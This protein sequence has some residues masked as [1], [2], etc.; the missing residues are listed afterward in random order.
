MKTSDEIATDIFR[1]VKRS[2]LAT[3][4]TGKIINGKERTPNSTKEDVTVK[5]LANNIGQKQGAYINVNVFVPD[6]I[7][8]GQ[9]EK[10]DSRVPL[11]ERTAMDVFDPPFHINGAR[12]VLDSQL[13]FPSE[14]GKEHI[15]N[16]KLLYHVINE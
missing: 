6:T 11:L 14:N 9:Y 12:I 7:R 16:N 8:S 10:D 4:V 2:A 13:V 1:Y 15:I 3:A 5:V